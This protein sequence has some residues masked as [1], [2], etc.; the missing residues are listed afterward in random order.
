MVMDDVIQ[1][2]GSPFSVMMGFVPIQSPIQDPPTP[3]HDVPVVVASSSAAAGTSAT[4]VSSTPAGL[5]QFANVPISPNVFRPI[6][7][8]SSP[9]K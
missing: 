7:K 5:Q 8:P 9:L 6:P 4:V 1:N 3:T 2:N